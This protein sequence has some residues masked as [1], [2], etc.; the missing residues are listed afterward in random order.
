MDCL[1]IGSHPAFL[2]ERRAERFEYGGSLAF[3]AGYNGPSMPMDLEKNRSLKVP[4][5]LRGHDASAARE[6]LARPW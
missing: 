1:H 6:L 2:S 4:Q 3:R 5:R